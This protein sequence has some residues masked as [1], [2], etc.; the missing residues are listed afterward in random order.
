MVRPKKKKKKDIYWQTDMKELL[1]F[2]VT[3]CNMQDLSSPVRDQ[4]C[5]LCCGSKV[6]TTGL[7]G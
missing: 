4:T 6:L 7:P 5:A 3:S 2:L 1:L